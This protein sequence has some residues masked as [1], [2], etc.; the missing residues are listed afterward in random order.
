MTDERKPLAP[1]RPDAGDLAVDWFCA[2]SIGAALGF[3]CYA[4]FPL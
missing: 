2:L 1:D 4:G 3:L